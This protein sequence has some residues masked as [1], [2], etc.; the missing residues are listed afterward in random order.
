MQNKND[1]STRK[2]SVWI[3]DGEENQF[4][5]K[6]GIISLCDHEIGTH[7]FRSYNDGNFKILIFQDFFN[8]ITK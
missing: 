1:P 7:Y 2:F 6:D 4:L 8:F 5:R 3:N